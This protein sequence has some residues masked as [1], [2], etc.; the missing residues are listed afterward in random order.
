MRQQQNGSPSETGDAMHWLLLI[1]GSLAAT[2]EVFLHKG[3]GRRYGGICTAIGA[4]LILFYSALWP[5][6]EPRPMLWFLAGYV[7]ACFFARIGA[8]G[9]LWNGSHSRYSGRPRIMRLL[10]FFSEN[11]IKR[12]IEPIVVFSIGVSLLPVT[13]PLGSYLILAAWG[14]FISTNAAEA[15]TRS[16]V[17]DLHD[18]VAEQRDIAERFRRSEGNDW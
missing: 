13:Q 17:Q 6:D 16:R 9:H 15:Q 3:F 18:S 11:T 10:P 5:G 14:L 1:C 8:V 4:L 2:C 12:M 7:L